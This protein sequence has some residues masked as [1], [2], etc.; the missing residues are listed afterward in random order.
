MLKK[1]IL[2]HSI[3]FSPDGVSTAYLY[4]DI[5]LKLKEANFDVIVLTTT[6]HY[7]AIEA[8]LKNQL[9]HKKLAG[10][11]YV[12]NYNGIKV[13]HIPQKKFNS[14]I[15]RLIGFIYWHIMSF[16]FALFQRNISVI[17]SPSPPLTI[18][19]INVLLS[20][21]KGLK[22]IY[23][24]Q[25]IYP[26]FLI[27]QG[28]LR[29]KPVINLLKWLEKYVYNH[30][31]AVT[32]IDEV[33]YDTIVGRIRDKSKLTIIPN[34]VDTTIFKPIDKNSIVLNK[35]DFPDN[36]KILK[37]MYAGNIGVAQD[38]DPLI[39]VAIKL[40][41]YP[42][43]FWIIGEGVKKNFLIEEIARRKLSNI[44][45][46]DYQPRDLMPQLI[47]YA[48]IHFIFM[49]PKMAGQG[50]PSKVYTIL[51]C[52]KPLLVLSGENTPIINFLQAQNSS[53]LITDGDAQI[54]TLKLEELLKYLSKNT[55]SLD[56]MGKKGKDVILKNYS[57]GAVTTKYID[58]ITKLCTDG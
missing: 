28:N 52:A 51:S 42:I 38:W 55:S 50:F 37:V 47:A 30:S 26:D 2:I 53:Y 1:R 43:E 5:A 4:N 58:L 19:F 25:E 34:F 15:L 35:V 8:Q 22:V 11:Y 48:D 40:Q 39:D 27:N 32:T 24:V 44:H 9:L 36:T 17:L 29:F 49:A 13:I 46:L 31:H 45:L 12:S 57:S 10:F 16:F 41:S 33:F 23:N 3:A 6:P 20:K 56:E 7:N 21:I 18:G 14:T 54:K